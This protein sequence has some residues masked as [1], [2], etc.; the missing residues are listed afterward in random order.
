M[1]LGR[2]AP[3]GGKKWRCKHEVTSLQQGGKSGL[4]EVVISSQGFTNSFLLH[5]D[6]G[7]AVR[8]RP[9]L[10]GTARI[11]LKAFLEK[12]CLGR[13]DRHLRVGAQVSDRVDKFLTIGKARH[14]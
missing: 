12:P 7:N 8:E 1:K 3:E 9:F 2:H 6:K 5:N 11:Q 10:V 13:C 4:L 14:L